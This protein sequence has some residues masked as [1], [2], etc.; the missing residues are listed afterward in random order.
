MVA[1]PPV[2]EHVALA[3]G[4]AIERD[5]PHGSEWARQ[6]F[7]G[8]MVGAHADAGSQ[9]VEP[10]DVTATAGRHA[11]FATPHVH[12]AHTAPASMGESVAPTIWIWGAGQG[13]GACA[14]SPS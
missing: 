6:E 14:G 5:P 8:T 13:D 2:A 9:L 10:K 3:A 11:T 1:P 4:V 7:V 12:G